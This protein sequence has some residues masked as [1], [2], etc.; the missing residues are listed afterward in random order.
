VR[1]RLHDMVHIDGELL[2]GATEVGFAGGGGGRLL[3]GDPYGS[4]L[5]LGFEA[6]Q[7][8]GNR[9]YSR[10]D[11]VVVP[12]VTVAPIVEVTNAPSAEHYGVR[13]LGEVGLDLGAGVGL[14]VRGGY[15]ARNFTSG[16]PSAGATAS[17]A[18]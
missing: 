16:G 9:F 2:A 8:F 18:F 11:A 14:A 3:L 15:Q 6:V 10:V 12:G 4:K 7:V 13:L 1:L 5:T 17:Y